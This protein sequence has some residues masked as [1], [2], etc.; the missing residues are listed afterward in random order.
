MFATETAMR[1]LFCAATC[2]QLLMVPTVRAQEVEDWPPPG[3]SF[4]GDTT[5]PDISGLWLGSVVGEPGGK[6][7]TN[8][9]A[10]GDGRTPIFMAPWPLPYT[11]EFQKVVDERQA[12]LQRGV[13]L[14]D[15]GAKCMPVGVP[16]LLLRNV[17]PQEIVQTPGNVALFGYGGLPIIIWTDGR[18]HPKDLKPSFN[19]HSV[20]YWV[21][22]TLHVDTVEIDARTGV[23]ATQFPHSD[24][25]QIKWTVRR[26]A[27][28]V[29]HFHITM[30]DEKAFTQPVV[31]TNI[32]ERKKNARWQVL[33]DGS[34]FENA[35][36]ISE[37]E[38]ADGF[39]R[40]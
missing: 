29:L 17:F 32:W 35:S 39:V 25:L 24:K 12:A 22:Q 19:G 40:F 18:G 7:F 37:K 38:P 16:P 14:G 21:G 2:V 23:G 6:A 33:D 10:S 20:G 4:Y 31:T 1:I 34:C 15:S 28:D 5:S 3:V 26:V 13:A 11:P 30:Y 36:G 9:G 27:P 8:S